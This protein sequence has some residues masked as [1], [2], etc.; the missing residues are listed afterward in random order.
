MYCV[1]SK[2]G[3]AIV[4]IVGTLA[5]FVNGIAASIAAANTDE[6]TSEYA[7]KIEIWTAVASFALV[8]L[9]FI[10]LIFAF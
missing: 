2:M 4:A 5:I 3:A 8:V 9:F 6:N 1:V 7:R 10:L